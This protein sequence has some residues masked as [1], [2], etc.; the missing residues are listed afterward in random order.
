MMKVSKV[1]FSFLFTIFI[2]ALV[3]QGT[4]LAK[5]GIKVVLYGSTLQGEHLPVM[6][7]N[8]VLVP[9]K[10]IFKTLG[11]TVSYDS[12]SKTISGDKSGTTIK[13][14][15]NQNI[16]WINNTPSTLQVAPQIINGST[17]VPLRFISEASGLEVKWYGKSQI[18]S[19][20]SKQNL[21]SASNGGEFGYINAQGK[22]VI[23]YQTKFTNAYPFSEGLAIV[24][25]SGKFAGFINQQ[26][27]LVIPKGN[28]Y[29]AKD[30]SEGLA[31]YR[32]L[33]TVSKYG[34]MDITGASVIK[35]QFKKAN[36]F[37]EGMAAVQIGSKY[38]YIDSLGKI[39]IKAQYDSAKDFSDGVA[40][41][42]INGA[43][44]YIDKKGK[45]LIN[46]DYSKADSFSEGLAAVKKGSKFGFI[47]KKG[48][49]E[50]PAIYEE[51]HSFSE[52]L[53]AVKINGKTGYLDNKGTMII[54]N[55]FDAAGDFYEGLAAAES[56]GKTGF[57]NKKGVWVIQPTLA[58][59][60]P[61]SNGL[62]YAYSEDGEVYINQTG[63]IV[64][65]I[66]Q[67]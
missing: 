55:Q 12:A 25:S 16:A 49:I 28:Y 11:F 32:T 40:L 27:E 47:N 37:S 23:D 46:A 18:V 7:N 53:A 35:P 30:F 58:W 8:T 39:I 6:K 31:A 42:S 62:S 20:Y 10:E 4:A 57:I 56:G 26:G 45:T 64:W 22:N 21:Y 29:D 50:I 59:A 14:V 15:I 17:Y 65:R 52:G 48:K 34:Y 51:A 61:F 60:Q 5:S 67:P 24:Y 19:L 33:D 13:L 38:G 66:N 2:I 63:Q 54:P 41:V 1:A 44:Y 9:F 3:S 36:N 43:F